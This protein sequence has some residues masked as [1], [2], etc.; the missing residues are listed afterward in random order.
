M[1]EIGGLYDRLKMGFN[2]PG[3]YEKY[4][5]PHEYGYDYSFLN[6]ALC[7]EPG[8]YYENGIGIEPMDTYLRQLPYPESR[9]IGAEN[10]N[11]RHGGCTLFPYTG[12]MGPAKYE[13][14]YEGDILDLGIYF[15]NY[16]LE[17]VAMKSYDSRHAEE[18]VV[19][20]LVN[21][22]DENADEEFFVYYGM[23]SGHGPYNTPERFRNQTEVGMLGEMIMEA[24]EIVGRILTKLESHGIADDTLIMFM[25]DNGPN[26][27]AEDIFEKLGH[28]QRQM[29][30][31]D[32]TSV[33]F[34]GKKNG[35]DEAG[36]RTPF[37]WRYPS[38][39][40]P[41]S[42][43]DPKVPISTVDVYAT[44]AELIDYD[45]ECN[46]APDSR[47]LV[48]YL[49]TGKANAELQQ[50]PIMTHANE[51][52]NQASLRRKN[53]KYVPAEKALYNLIWDP[54]A[55]NNLFYDEEQQ[56][57]VAYLDDYLKDWLAHL[58][59]RESA[60]E[61]GKKKESCFPEFQRYKHLNL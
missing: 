56:P 20:K 31:P 15:C 10:F 43:Y 41:K 39:F 29:D 7:C 42:I 51:R 38:R 5:L 48:T 3:L 60:T 9:P 58:E 11:R 28:N 53:F 13:E 59:A 24:D 21:F 1:D 34:P 50:K 26:A 25:S 37:L 54:E 45:L 8:G 2:T 23:R 19:P 6:S 17:T 32:G 33:V 47:S 52:G 61:K 27:S 14:P 22:I 18:K 57:F 55:K 36:H 16:A 40:T 49:E 44:L 46:E 4:Y 30:L 35:Q 12:Y